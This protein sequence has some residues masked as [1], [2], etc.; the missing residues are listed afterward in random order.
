MTRTGRILKLVAITLVALVP[1][2]WIA[3]EVY[4]T[5]SR[6]VI[7]KVVA[8]VREF[9]A[10]KTTITEAGERLQSVTGRKASPSL[11]TD[12]SKEIEY[13]LVVP[14]GGLKGLGRVFWFTVTL[15]FDSADRLAS[16]RVLF[17]SNSYAC[18]SVE[19]WELASLAGR[20]DGEFKVARYDPY[21][22]IVH[23][24]PNASTSDNQMAWNWQ[25]SC[26][27]SVEGCNDVRRVLPSL[28]PL[29][30]IE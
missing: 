29:H 14:Q 12:G 3:N 15:K 11:D 27:T 5:H 9:N 26:L 7:E 13:S 4:A 19:V 8:A 24:G 25:L 28:R 18:C 2:S 16:K 23:L 21:S 30:R 22:I 10:N 1:C 20:D 17:T 6:K